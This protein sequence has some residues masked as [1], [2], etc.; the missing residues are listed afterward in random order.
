MTAKSAPLDQ[1]GSSMISAPKSFG[2]ISSLS[3]IALLIIG[4]LAL[5][6]H[7]VLTRSIHWDEFHFYGQ[8]ADYVRGNEISP[9]QT[10]HVQFFAWIPGLVE[11]GIDGIVIGR[12][13]MFGCQLITLASIASIA[14]RFVTRE[15]AWLTVL[16]YLS[17]GY[18]LQHGWSFRTD[19]LAT[20][21]IMSS[22]AVLTRARLN[23]MFVPVAGVLIGLAG[24]VTVKAILLAPAF[25]GMAWL[26]WSEARFS[27]PRG[28]TIIAIPAIAAATFFALYAVH[29]DAVSAGEA[30]TSL[31]SAGGAGQSMLLAGLPPYLRFLAKGAIIAF[32]LVVLIT[33]AVPQIRA[34]KRDEKFALIGCVA[35][36]LALAIYRNTFPYFYPMMLAP[37]AAACA[38]GLNHLVPR[39]SVR[40]IAMVAA[41]NAAG[42]WVIDGASRLPQQREIISAAQEIF[43]E[44]VA[45]FDF[46]NMLTDFDKANGFLT[47]W[48]LEDSRAA[49]GESTYRAI[50]ESKPV[51]LLLTIDWT[52]HANLLAVM[53]DM[54]RKELFAEADQRL[55]KQTYR[56][57]WGP[58]WLAGTQVS[59]GE[60]AA[61]EVMV[62]GTYTVTGSDIAIDGTG[63]QSGETLVLDHGVVNMTN[64]SADSAGIIWGDK[65]KRPEKAPPQ[66]PY[67]TRF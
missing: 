2:G 61:Y 26:R 9:F 63:Y 46:P 17:A 50:L 45:Y 44:P 59:A 57:F 8:L 6:F 18:T 31:Q 20:A 37:V 33:Y 66:R 65:L 49:E 60:Q 12:M 48:G 24:L 10:F 54:P 23:F 47:T 42:V 19:P 53:E 41:I 15:Y 3:L 40:L 34:H 29:S 5:E 55:L 67:W 14:Q 62:P 51:P 25:A 64:N 22:L 38:V 28:A 36:L 35:T 4:V 7:L 43:P 1:S 16:I 30:A 27:T 52:R 58:F 56:R 11:N 32:P 39:Y 21:L 13:V